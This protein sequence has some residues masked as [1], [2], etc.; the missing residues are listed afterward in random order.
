M[1]LVFNTRISCTSEGE[2]CN[3]WLK[4]A[5]FCNTRVIKSDNGWTQIRLDKEKNVI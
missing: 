3:K 5:P 4:V 2:I 1:W